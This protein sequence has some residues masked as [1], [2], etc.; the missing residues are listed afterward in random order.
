MFKSMLL[1]VFALVIFQN[2]LQAQD[3]S[4]EEAIQKELVSVKIKITGHS[5]ECVQLTLVNTAKRYV[6]VVLTPGDVL[7]AEDSTVQNLLVVDAGVFNL[8]A[9]QKKQI[10]L[11]AYC[12]KMHKS[13]PS[14]LNSFQF[15]GKTS[16]NLTKI[17]TYLHKNQLKSSPMAQEAIWAVSDAA[18]LSLIYDKINKEKAKKL[19]EYVAEITGQ[20]VPWFRLEAKKVNPGP[21]IV[22]RELVKMH[23]DWE[24]VLA[25]DDVVTFI[26]ADAQGKQIASFFEEKKY[27]SGKYIFSFS[28]ETNKLAKGSYFFRM[29]GKSLGKIEERK[30][31]LM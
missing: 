23:A 3:I 10:N 28:Y 4:L 13:G 29:T 15:S 14:E 1:C 20:K 6:K 22:K 27:K 30:V 11:T 8:Q 31:D 18:S 9:N 19:I 12:C 24:F 26:V 17:A 21:Q 25:Q 7:V 16:E 2:R 5:G